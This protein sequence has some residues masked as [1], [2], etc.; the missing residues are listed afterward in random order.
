[1]IIRIFEICVRF[2][3]DGELVGAP[4]KWEAA[5]SA[6]NVCTMFYVDGIL[7]GASGKN[8]KMHTN[9]YQTTFKTQKYGSAPFPRNT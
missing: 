1:M 8:T 7:V 2:V 9:T 3:L 5:L 4:N 6:Q